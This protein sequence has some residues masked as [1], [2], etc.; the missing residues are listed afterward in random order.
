MA[1][2]RQSEPAPSVRT[3][4]T[5]R[6]KASGGGLTLQADVFKAAAKAKSKQAATIGGKALREA[7]V[8]GRNILVGGSRTSSSSDALV[9]FK[10]KSGIPSCR[11]CML[12]AVATIDPATSARTLRIKKNNGAIVM[13]IDDAIDACLR[14]FSCYTAWLDCFQCISKLRQRRR[15]MRIPKTPN[16]T[17]ATTTTTK[18]IHNEHIN[19]HMHTY[20]SIPL[21]YVHSKVYNA[22]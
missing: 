2:G 8:E 14:C 9:L 17:T 20:K 19:I 16:H 11:R 1:K 4:R 13:I 22:F 3:A 12:E 6:T 18:S 10:S 15:V 5:S 7:L 21:C